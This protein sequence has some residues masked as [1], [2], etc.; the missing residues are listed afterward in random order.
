MADIS[1][2]ETVTR[3]E[4]LAF[5]GAGIDTVEGFWER[6]GEGTDEAILRLSTVTSIQET[7]LRDL[8]MQLPD[9]SKLRGIKSDEEQRLRSAGIEKV[10]GFWRRVRQGGDNAVRQLGNDTGIEEDRL[11]EILSAQGDPDHR[12][13]GYVMP[14]LSLLALGLLA[15]AALAGVCQLRSDAKVVIAA[16]ELESGH[17]LRSVDLSSASLRRG[18]DY[19]TSSEVAPTVMSGTPPAVACSKSLEGAIL[20]RDIT[21]GRPLRHTDVLCPQVVAAKDLSIG[22]VI[23]KDA[24]KA[25]WSPY[26]PQAALNVNQVIGHPLRRAIRKDQVVREDYL[27]AVPG[28]V[29]VRAA[30]A[31]SPYQVIGPGD[32]TL[33]VVPRETAALASKDAAVGH[34][35]LRAIPQGATLHAGDVSELSVQ[36]A[37]LRDRE[38]LSVPVA[39]GTLSRA[40]VTG[41]RVSLLFSPRGHVLPGSAARSTS[42]TVDEAIVLSVVQQGTSAS[43]V[44]AVTEADLQAVRSLLGTSEVFVSRD[45]P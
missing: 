30:A 12:V 36:E 9:I 27:Q 40:I 18:E 14:A 29:V 45:V 38:S 3:S 39:P 28:Q 20:A 7:R 25:A 26:E 41:A 8:L 22:D 13:A 37:D 2:I 15:L 23:A 4:I 34:H 43:L 33:T 16:R 35:T 6:A 10:E 44:V 21:V 32:V 31:L 19:F 24:V 17:V 1:T 42:I 11:T 5:R